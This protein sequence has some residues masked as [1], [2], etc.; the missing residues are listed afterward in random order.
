VVAYCKRKEKGGSKARTTKT[1]KVE[2]DLT[3][4]TLVPSSNLEGA[5]H[6]GMFHGSNR[7]RKSK[8]MIT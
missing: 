1:G 4:E 2:G 5:D 8:R 7:Q 6:F 3:R